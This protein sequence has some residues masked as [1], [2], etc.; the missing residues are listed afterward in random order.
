MHEVGV[1]IIHRNINCKTGMRIIHR[2]GLYTG[3][4]DNKLNYPLNSLTPDIPDI[5]IYIYISIYLYNSI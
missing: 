2:C 4:D 5:P 1:R 3:K